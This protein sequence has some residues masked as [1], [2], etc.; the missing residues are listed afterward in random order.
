M[1][2]RV[3]ITR[4]GIAPPAGFKSRNRVPTAGMEFE[5]LDWS[6]KRLSTVDGVV[7]DQIQRHPLSMVG[8]AL[9]LGVAIGWL[10]KKR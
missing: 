6:Q 8:G 5:W 9:I 10:I 4:V 1:M 2:R 7:R 3:P